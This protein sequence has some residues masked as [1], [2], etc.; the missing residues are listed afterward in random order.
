M[1][2]HESASAHRKL[3]ILL[4]TC[5][6]AVLLVGGAYAGWKVRKRMMIQT[7]FTAGSAAYERGD[8]DTARR[9]LGRYVSAHPE[10]LDVLAKYARAQLSVRPLPQD[11]IRQAMNAYRLILR[12][13]PSDELAF[14]RL[15]LLYETT[16]NLAELEYIAEQRCEAVPGD[17][18]ATVA[19]AKALLYR[20]KQADGRAALE[21]LVARL[22]EE[23]AQRTEFIEASVLLCMLEAQAV[24]LGGDATREAAALAWLTRALEYD[25]DSALAHVQRATLLR[26][27]AERARRPLNEADV[28]TARRDLEEAANSN[29]PDPRVWLAL[30]EEWLAQGASDHA[31]AQ[32]E[33][34]SQVDPESLTEF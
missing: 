29:S 14:R 16:G 12:A 28:A 4:A 7:A 3:K 22:A 30:S 20:E 5:L 17:P 18:A 2:A 19:H 9:M 23:H 34:A 33:S 15:A 32:L 8:W 6:I 31:A 10:D 26:T 25:P 11:G 21:S 27:L 1:A 13:R 24:P